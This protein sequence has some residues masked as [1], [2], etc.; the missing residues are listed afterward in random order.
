[1]ASS[2]RC[3]ECGSAAVEEDAHYSQSHLVCTDCGCLLSEGLLT[4][5]RSEEA[6]LQAVRYTDSTAEVRKPCRNKLQGMR[7][8][9]DLCQILRLRPVLQDSASELYSR[10]YDHPDF[11]HL[12]LDKKEALVGCCVQV[13]C[14]QHNWPLT[15]GTLCSLLHVPPPLFSAVFLQ[16]I[17]DLQL[18]I[19]SLCLHDLVKT[20]CDG[21]QL[22]QNSGRVPAVYVEDKDKLVQR[23]LQLVELA[24]E[25]WLVTGRHPVPIL[26]AAAY[27]SWQSLQ[28]VQR[29][30]CSLGR[31]CRMAGIGLPPPA[32]QRVREM[33]GV[34]A[35]LAA[36]LP[37]LPT[38][39]VDA[40]TAVKYAGDV[41]RHRDL[42]LRRTL[43]RAGA[44]YK[45]GEG[46]SSDLQQQ[47][48][49]AQGD[50]SGSGHQ[51][52]PCQVQGDEGIS[53]H[54]SQQC[55][56]QGDEGISGHQSQPCQAQGD[57][58]ISGHQSQLCQVH[59]EGNSEVMH[60]SYEQDGG[61]NSHQ[62]EPCRVQGDDGNSGVKQWVSQAQ[63]KGSS[64]LQQQP[65]Q[66][67]GEVGNSRLQP[68][69]CQAQGDKGN[70]GHQLQPCWAQGDEGSSEVQQWVNRAH[71]ESS[72]GHQ[73][74]SQAREPGA[75]QK[76]SAPVFLP[77]C[78]T[79]TKR[80]RF[81]RESEGSCSGPIVTGEEEIS[82][83]EIE[84]YLRTPD[85]VAAFQA[86][87]AILTQ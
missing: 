48:C 31:F 42:L 49:Q 51:S 79:Q 3:P 63:G 37:W 4:T 7:R 25:T 72:S 18:D 43:D 17:K 41:L 78:L 46:G 23:A 82:D 39:T 24:A 81:R 87:N 47:L 84:Q 60:V 65:C 35:T 28:P 38:Q 40:R 11:L 10:A 62:Q 58:G 30:S 85:E 5:A 86:A 67:Q 55:R 20:H 22:F 15:M 73:Q 32:P 64:K 6:F 2:L 45:C 56:A 26:T 1:M 44:E 66:A 53:G 16:L 83:S 52:Q 75:S 34:L 69:P 50:K 36:Q 54:Q 21:L 13:S 57:D 19:P 12:G 33:T 74:Q 76:H 80:R 61:N 27:L 8:V 77:P 70:N 59:S 29:L 14:R 71:P 9:R 68:L